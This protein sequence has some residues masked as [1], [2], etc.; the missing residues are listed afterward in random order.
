L[1]GKSEA[2]KS[3]SNR[4]S[5]LPQLHAKKQGPQSEIAQQINRFSKVVNGMLHDKDREKMKRK[6]K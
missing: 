5:S 1:D 4:Q 2:A 3:V 6:I